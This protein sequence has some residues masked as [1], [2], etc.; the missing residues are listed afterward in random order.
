MKTIGCKKPVG[1][2]TAQGKSNTPS[3]RLCNEAI[4]L[5]EILVGI[6]IK[7]AVLLS[8]HI[9]ERGFSVNDSGFEEYLNLEV[10]KRVKKIL[11]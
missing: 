5:A 4:S 3:D 9:K 8:M 2:G 6:A 1:Q 10:A 11:D 7:E